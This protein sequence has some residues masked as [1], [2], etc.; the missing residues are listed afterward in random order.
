VLQKVYGFTDVFNMCLLRIALKEAA[1]TEQGAAAAG[2]G[3]EG[4]LFDLPVSWFDSEWRWSMAMG[5]G[6]LCACKC[7]DVNQPLECARLLA[8][9]DRCL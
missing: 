8:V 6:G 9:S 1:N 7:N 2:L 4:R 3:P 5:G